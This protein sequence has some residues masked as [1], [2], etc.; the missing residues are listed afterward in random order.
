MRLGLLAVAG[1][2]VCAPAFADLVPPKPQPQAQTAAGDMVLSCTGPFVKTATHASLV[3]HFGAKNVAWETVDGPEG[4]TYQVTAIYPKEPK[5]RLEVIWRDEA[6]RKDLLG[7]DV[8]SENTMWTGPGGLK[9]KMPIAQVEKLNGKP[10]MLTGYEWDMW[11]QVVDWKN[12]KMPAVAKAAGCDVV[13][14]RLDATGDTSTVGGEG[15]FASN[16]KGM[17][18]AKPV[19]ESFGVGI[20]YPEAAQ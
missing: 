10:F 13:T 19:V 7:L 17:K 1:I 16:S 2:F 18:K 9:M 5:K 12:G 14:V 15:P 6:G 11:G 8:K 20:A 4:S 3:K